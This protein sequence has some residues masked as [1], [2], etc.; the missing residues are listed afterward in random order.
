MRTTSENTTGLLVAAS[1]III[2]ILFASCGGETKG[3]QPAQGESEVAPAVGQEQILSG[4]QLA[5]YNGLTEENK[6]QFTDLLPQALQDVHPEDRDLAVDRFASMAQRSQDHL[7]ALKEEPLIELPPLRQTLSTQEQERLD[8]LDHRLRKAFIWWWEGFREAE[9][10]ITSGQVEFIVAQR[11]MVLGALPI[12]ELSASD[13][14]SPDSVAE[15]NSFS[16]HSQDYFWRAIAGQMTEG[17]AF[18][19][20]PDTGMCCVVS[21]QNLDLDP[22]YLKAYAAWQL[23]HAK[24]INDPTSGT[25]SPEFTYNSNP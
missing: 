16:E 2:C 10:Y 20:D 22:D 25:P 12:R 15:L 18:M 9:S 21:K 11:R 6:Q 13:F 7:R 8:A 1:W 24:Y 23:E 5:A 4:G 19:P 3:V 14:L 17:S